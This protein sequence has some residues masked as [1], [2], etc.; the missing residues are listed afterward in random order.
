[1]TG[2]I[3]PDIFRNS[4]LQLFADFATLKGGSRSE[5]ARVTDSGSK[6][7]GMSLQQSWNVRRSK[8][9]ELGK[10]AREDN[11]KVRN[12]LVRALTAEYQVK[13]LSA[14]PRKVRAALVGRGAVTAAQDFQFDANGNSTSGKP[15]TR[16]RITAVLKAVTAD[17]DEVHKKAFKMLSARAKSAGLNHLFSRFFNLRG[18]Y[19]KF[20]KPFLD[21]A[22][23]SQAYSRRDLERYLKEY[24]F[25]RNADNAKNNLQLDDNLIKLKDD[26][27]QL[28][29]GRGVTESV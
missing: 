17:H 8:S 13:D 15:L 26:I 18:Q 5:S 24:F 11:N 7:G 25:Y 29:K 6:I 23:K 2:A 1:M 27:K 12:R 21:E 28:L 20:L 3:N 16:R 10:T 14:L 19:A 9:S 4:D 22:I